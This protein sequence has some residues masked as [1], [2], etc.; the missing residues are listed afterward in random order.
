MQFYREFE[1]RTARCSGFLVRW[2]RRPR[3]LTYGIREE[4][5]FPS[6]FNCG[7]NGT[8]AISNRFGAL[9]S[10]C[11]VDCQFYEHSVGKVRNETFWLD[12]TA[13]QCDS[14]LVPRLSPWLKVFSLVLSLAKRC[15][16]IYVR[17]SAHTKIDFW[18][19]CTLF[20]LIKK[21]HYSFFPL[22]LRCI[23]IQSK[24]IKFFL[25]KLVKLIL[26]TP[27]LAITG[28]AD[29]KTQDVI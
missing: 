4:F 1:G 9:S 3:C 25:A 23:L 8:R 24:S 16:I 11:S 14:Y 12:K 22:H 26:G 15:G 28:T 19:A 2:T 21:H 29:D 6:C 13:I 18:H 20:I 7:R 27:V 17:I 10:S 5:D